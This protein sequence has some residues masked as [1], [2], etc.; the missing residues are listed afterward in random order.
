MLAYYEYLDPHWCQIYLYPL[1][2]ELKV[3]KS[4]PAFMDFPFINYLVSRDHYFPSSKFNDI[5]RSGD[6]PDGPAA[7]VV[8]RPWFP[9]FVTAV[10]RPTG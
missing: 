3:Y 6:I 2:F 1:T 10:S 7:L 9:G 8:L 5:F 4:R